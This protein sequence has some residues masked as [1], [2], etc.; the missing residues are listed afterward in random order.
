MRADYTNLVYYCT[1]PLKGF[2]IKIIHHFNS[3]SAQPRERALPCAADFLSKQHFTL[4]SSLSV[5][6]FSHSQILIFRGIFFPPPFFL[7][8]LLLATFE[9]VL[10][11]HCCCCCVSPYSPHHLCSA[12]DAPLRCTM[13]GACSYLIYSLY[14]NWGRE[15]SMTS[16][17]FTTLSW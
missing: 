4:K 8:L 1:V 7:T 3:C 16:P 13:C 15:V 6:S 11:F 14:S 5:L 2:F 12:K 9:G 17:V 10:L